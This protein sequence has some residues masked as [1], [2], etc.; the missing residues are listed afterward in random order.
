MFRSTIIDKL[1]ATI[2]PAGIDLSML[3]LVSIL[4]GQ[5]WLNFNPDH[6]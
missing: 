5:Q 4:A 2:K 6:N 3:A 1:Q